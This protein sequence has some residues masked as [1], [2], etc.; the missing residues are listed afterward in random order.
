M[1][2]KIGSD[3]F[4]HGKQIPRRFTGEGEDVSPPLW[5]DG[6]PDGTKQL[7]LICDDPD[8]P[9]QEPWV[10]WVLYGLPEGTTSLPEGVPASERLELPSGALQGKNSWPHGV[11][12]GYRGPMP[13]EG[14]GL[15]HYRF[16][17]Y[18]LDN[19]FDFQPGLEKQTILSAITGHVLAEAELVGTYER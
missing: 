16:R 1:G 19:A 11:T 5:W 6:V 17:L 3:A 10:H 7:V 2:M 14:H 4:E 12:T 8:A 9:T 15:H 13:P 18:A